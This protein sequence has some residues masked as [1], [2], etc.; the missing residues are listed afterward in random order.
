MAVLRTKGLSTKVTE[1]EYAMFER[2]ADG[3]TLSE[4]IR[5]VLLKAAATQ[6]AEAVVLA[7]VLALR[8]IV[9]NL[10]FKISNGQPITAE[11]MQRLINRADGD[12]VQRAHERLTPAA[13]GARDE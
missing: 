1:D 9:L 7:E 10:L 4:W 13:T 3:Q 12:K 6:R 8:T 11:D 2:L 5:D